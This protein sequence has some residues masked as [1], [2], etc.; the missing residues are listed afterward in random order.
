MKK[1]QNFS[2]KSSNPP[3]LWSL[4]LVLLR[5]VPPVSGMAWP[6]TGLD[7]DCGQGVG[8]TAA[9]LLWFVGF[10]SRCG[11]RK[12]REYIMDLFFALLYTETCL[13]QSRK[14]LYRGSSTTR[15]EFG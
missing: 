12:S 11:G 2:S 6:A 1:M 15:Y 10:G 9:P 13:K 4:G 5:S 8:G 14:S 7:G 3:F